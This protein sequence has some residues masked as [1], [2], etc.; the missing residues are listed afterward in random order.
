ME[1]AASWCG[2][3]VVLAQLRHELVKDGIVLGLGEGELVYARRE[4]WFFGVAFDPQFA[5]EGEHRWQTK[6]V[7][8]VSMS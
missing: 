8:V 4:E 7:V 6:D 2:S 1:G 5:A 3:V